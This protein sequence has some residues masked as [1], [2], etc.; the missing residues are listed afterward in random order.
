MNTSIVT[1]LGQNVQSVKECF[2]VIYTASR[3]LL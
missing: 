2:L 3:M 1:L